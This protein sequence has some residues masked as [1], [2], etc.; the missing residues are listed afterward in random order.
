MAASVER[1]EGQAALTYGDIYAPLTSGGGAAKGAS[2]GGV[3]RMDVSGTLALHGTISADGGSSPWWR[4]RRLHR[5]EGQRPLGRASSARLAGTE[6]LT[7]PAVTGAQRRRRCGAGAS[8]FTATSPS[9]TGSLPRR[10]MS[11]CWLSAV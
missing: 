10:C 7:N 1:A 11:M 6:P 2:G 8:R 4:S 5:L 9:S 3:I